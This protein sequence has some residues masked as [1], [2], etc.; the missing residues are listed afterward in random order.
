MQYEQ[1]TVVALSQVR[2]VFARSNTGIVASN[3]NQGM[4]VYVYSVFVLGSGFAT[5]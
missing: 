4:H 3:P 5:G 2:T 1:I